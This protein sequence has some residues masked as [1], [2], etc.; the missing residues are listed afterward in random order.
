ME[1]EELEFD[2]VK[3][4][5]K[6]YWDRAK[7]H[8]FFKDSEEEAVWKKSLNEEFGAGKLKILD[9]GTGNGSLALLLAEMGHDVVGIDISKEMLSVARKKAEER[10]VNPDLGIGDAESLEFKD[11][12]FDA[13]VSRIVLWTLP[14]P[15][16][17]ISEW[18]RVLK[19]GGKVYTFEFDSSGKRKGAVGAIKKNLG[20]LLITIIEREN[21]WM[22]EHYSRDVNEKLPLYY[23]KDTSNAINKV[24]LFRKGGFD[25]V[26]IFELE[27]V[28]EVARKKQEE[29]PLRHKLALGYLGDY[30]WYY[31]RGCKPSK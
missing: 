11:E 16:K 14:H 8:A 3:E 15:E 9:I 1:K 4:E 27:E 19:A 30:V 26:L 7:E 5:I 31:I 24:E 28:S 25:D 29:F 6:E 12:S 18:K 22:M 10:G 17:A 13:V 21:A 20:L 23:E 2:W